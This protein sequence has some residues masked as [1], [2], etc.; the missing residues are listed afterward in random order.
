MLYYSVKYA[1]LRVFCFGVL[2]TL[3][4]AWMTKIKQNNKNVLISR[5][6]VVQAGVAGAMILSAP[7]IMAQAFARVVVIGGG[8]GGILTARKLAALDPS[9]K[10][11]VIEGNKNYLTPFVGNQALVGM[12]S[13]NDLTYSYGRVGATPNIDM[14]YGWVTEIDATKRR[15]RLKDGRTL[16]YDRL[17]VAP[18]IGFVPGAVEGYDKAA[19]EKFPHAYITDGPAQWKNLAARIKAM[20]DGGTFAISI[21]NH[22][23]RCSPAPYARATLIANYFKQQKPNSTVQIFD[24]NDAFPFMD[25]MIPLWENEF[26]ENVEWIPADFGGKVTRVD[27][28]SGIIIAGDE[29]FN[30]DVV[31]IIPAQRAGK[32]AIDAGLVDD[33]GWCP[34]AP[35]TLISTKHPDIH[36]L[37]DAAD[38]G[39]MPKSAASASSQSLAVAAAVYSAVTGKKS[40]LD[41]YAAAC[42][43]LLKDKEALVSSGRYQPKGNRIVGVEGFASAVGDDIDDRKKT[44]LLA[45][46]WYADIT[47]AM[48][49]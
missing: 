27:A 42:Y 13:L 35:D 30:P 46:Q 16:D 24:A 25:L 45:N 18:G 22:P 47:I 6:R 11:S 5:R 31:N 10:I 15:V 29:E 48:F 49:A 33:T 8:P 40:K 21:P 32:I 28:E 1:H 12:K 34:V 41:D 17:I 14:V 39:D 2:T 43:F 44:A 37:G 19:Q 9:I 23:Y 38:A 36:I 4:A 3:G 20:D 26:A 7:K